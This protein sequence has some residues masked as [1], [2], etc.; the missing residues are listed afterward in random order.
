MKKFK[1]TEDFV[2]EILTRNP[3]TRSDD[4]LLY[5]VVCEKVNKDTLMLPFCVVVTNR[6]SMGLP[7]FKSV[8]RCRRKLQNEFPELCANSYV[9]GYRILEEEEYK[10]YG[11]I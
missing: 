4:D 9:E 2:K 3:L 11:R 6:K 5:A 1:K 8:E 10:N 7:S